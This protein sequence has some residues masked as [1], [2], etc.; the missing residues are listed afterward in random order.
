MG[1]AIEVNPKNRAAL[2]LAGGIHEQRGDI[3]KAREHHEGD[4]G[5]ARGQQRRRRGRGRG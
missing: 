3:P 4:G 2:M 1:K 5:Q